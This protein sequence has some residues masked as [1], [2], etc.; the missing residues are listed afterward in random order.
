MM[1]RPW[2]GTNYEQGIDGKRVL[3]LGES[4]YD[5]ATVRDADYSDIVCENVRDCAIN[6]RVRFF[7][8]TAKLVLK[9]AG[10]ER[11]SRDD[12][13]DLW[14]RVLFTNYVP[15]VFASDRVR[16][17]EDDWSLGR[18]ALLQVLE[19][20]SPG[21]IVALGLALGSRLD[22]LSDA[23]PAVKVAA[24]AH[25]S[26]FGFK[27]ERWTPVVAGVLGHDVRASG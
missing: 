4:N 12:I 13:I 9:A 24:V 8:K 5:K 17:S 7:T 22:W 10:R 3:L 14:Q 18:P 19:T 25:P 15:T 1:I 6:G 21:V 27:Y 2:V 16:P 23:A 11:I 26:S 20:H